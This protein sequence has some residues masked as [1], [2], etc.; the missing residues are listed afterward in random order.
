MF[1]TE[2]YGVAAVLLIIMVL[3]FRWPSTQLHRPRLGHFLG[4]GF[5]A[6]LTFIVVIV[7]TYA[8]VSHGIR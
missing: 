4:V 5:L 6:G 3:T 2:L 8:L 1:L 7:P